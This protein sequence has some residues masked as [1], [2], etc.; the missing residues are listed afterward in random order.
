MKI[1]DIFKTNA[2]TFSFEFF[3]AKDIPQ[4]LGLGASIGQ[5]MR[6]NPSFVSVTYGAGGSSQAFSFE[7]ADYLQNNIGF[8]TM[9]H[10]T[11]V[12]AR[13]EKA[14]SDFAALRKKGIEN[15]MLLRGD[16]PTGTPAVDYGKDGFRY[17]L[18]LVTVVD[19]KDFAIGVAGYPETHP[20]AESPERDIAHLK[21]KLDAG[22]D[23][24]ITQMFFDNAYYFDYVKRAENA[25]VRARIIPGIMPLT[26]AKQI[27]RF[28]EKSGAHIPETTIDALL[29]H[30]GNANKMY[31]A[32]IDIAAEQCREL[33]A[34]G[35]PGLHF[36]TLNK[37]NATIDIYDTLMMGKRAGIGAELK[38]ID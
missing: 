10:Y 37:S 38:R 16:P 32:G 9:A 7:L 35:A 18:D 3:A 1:T 26:S 8:V 23:F 31:Q 15:L 27:E 6:I 30:E 14:Q 19:K 22:G 11:C 36:Y 12:N 34:C 2:K 28:K 21:A 33:L 5:L 20:E 25:G 24:V 4:A 13:R 17:A 29:R